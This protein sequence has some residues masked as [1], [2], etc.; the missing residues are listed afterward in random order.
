MLH[1]IFH[2]CSG[3]FHGHSIINLL[4]SVQLKTIK[5]F[6]IWQRYSNSRNDL[7]FDLTVHIQIHRNTDIIHRVK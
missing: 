6:N 3:T 1:L 7:Y 4:L 5:M 2:Q